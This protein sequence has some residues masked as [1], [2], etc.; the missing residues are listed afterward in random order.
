MTINNCD[1]Q[2][3]NVFKGT[4]CSLAS[5]ES[6][7][8]NSYSIIQDTELAYQC[9]WVPTTNACKSYNNDSPIQANICRIPTNQQTN[10]NT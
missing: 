5:D 8:S 1:I 3:K 10:R 9:V 4:D 6:T 7:C 2:D